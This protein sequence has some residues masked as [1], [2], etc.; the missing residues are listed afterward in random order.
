MEAKKLEQT[1]GGRL[2]KKIS[3][4]KRSIIEQEFS[5]PRKK[6]PQRSSGSWFYRRREYRSFPYERAARS[7]RL[8][9]ERRHRLIRPLGNG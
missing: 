4:I 2:T 9:R 5:L 8:E 6:F 3:K 1:R 7:T